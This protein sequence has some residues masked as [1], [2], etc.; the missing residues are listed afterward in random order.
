M[1]PLTYRK[2]SEELAEAIEHVRQAGAKDIKMPPVED[3]EPVYY[4]MKE[5]IG[6]QA[7]PEKESNS[8]AQYAAT[9]L[10]A[11][12]GGMPAGSMFV[13][14]DPCMLENRETLTGKYG[15]GI[16]SV[17]ELMSMPNLK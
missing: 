1:S 4:A 3:V 16:I 5:L 8:L 7:D 11:Q 14:D 6:W 12:R 17:R 2:P 15:V 10:V 13:T 9:C